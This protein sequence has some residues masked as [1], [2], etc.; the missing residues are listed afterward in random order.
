LTAEQRRDL[1]A[2][3]VKIDE[4][5]AAYNN[6]VVDMSV[7][8]LTRTQLA[9]LVD[10]LQKEARGAYAGF[11]ELQGRVARALGSI[12]EA[13]QLEKQH[14]EGDAI[15][16]SEIEDEVQ[17]GSPRQDEAQK[18]TMMQDQSQLADDSQQ[19]VQQAQRPS[20]THIQESH[21]QKKPVNPATDATDSNRHINIVDQAAPQNRML[22]Q[23]FAPKIHLG[24]SRGMQN[25]KSEQSGAASQVQSVPPMQQTQ[26]MASVPQQAPAHSTQVPGDAAQAS[27]V[28]QQGMAPPQK[29]APQLNAS[30]PNTTQS[31]QPRQLPQSSQQPEQPE[32]QGSS[33]PPSD[34]Q[35]LQAPEPVGPGSAVGG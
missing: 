23:E 14:L 8:Q 1:E 5:V 30:D 2:T 20:Y 22:E 15:A 21:Q 26:A 25:I 10:L 7:A 28:V 13:E 16:L 18:Q 3:I 34:G 32:Q 29:P 35:P 19:T 27:G 4:Q 11:N 9:R 33:S 6:L 31:L 17:Q 24:G 12:P